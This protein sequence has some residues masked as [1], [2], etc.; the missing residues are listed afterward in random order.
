MISGRLETILIK[1][2]A[3]SKIAP[4]EVTNSPA[5]SSSAEIVF[6]IEICPLE[7]VKVMD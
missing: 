1:K 7:P 4:E 2:L 6:S 5:F 3:S